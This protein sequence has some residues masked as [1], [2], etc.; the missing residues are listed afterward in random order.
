MRDAFGFG[1]GPGHTALVE[2]PRVQ[3]HIQSPR[4][5]WISTSPFGWNPT[6]SGDVDIQRLL[7]PERHHKTQRTRDASNP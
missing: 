5:P 2:V 4:N 7:S 3:A 1:L 6:P